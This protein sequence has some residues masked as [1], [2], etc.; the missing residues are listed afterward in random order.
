MSA[1]P[2]ELLDTY[3]MPEAHSFDAGR[4]WAPIA[5]TPAFIISLFLTAQ[6]S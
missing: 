4:T 1:V 3:R 2:N 6:A 5:A